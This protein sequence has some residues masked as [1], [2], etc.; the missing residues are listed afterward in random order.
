[1]Q[2]WENMDVSELLT[3]T[4]QQ[5]TTSLRAWHW[6]ATQGDVGCSWLTRE[7]GSKATGERRKAHTTWCGGGLNTEASHPRQLSEKL[8]PWPILKSLSPEPWAAT[9]LPSSSQ[10]WQRVQSVLKWLSLVK[11]VPKGQGRQVESPQGSVQGAFM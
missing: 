1:M 6:L 3:A 10:T 4:K 8:W 7:T 9:P 11:K 5:R 2:G